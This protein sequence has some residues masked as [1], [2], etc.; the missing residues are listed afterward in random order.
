MLDVDVRDQTHLALRI[1]F[2]VEWRQSIELH[3]FMGVHLGRL[4][5]GVIVA[6]CL[7]RLVL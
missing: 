1:R 2:I 7:R 5:R 6:K 4:V 3:H